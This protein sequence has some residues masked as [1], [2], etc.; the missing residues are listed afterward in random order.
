MSM[1][2]PSFFDHN[3]SSTAEM[4]LVASLVILSDSFSLAIS[5]N[6]IIIEAAIEEESMTHNFNPY[7]SLTSRSMGIDPA[8]GNW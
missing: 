2:E 7:Y 8:Y 6:F 1:Y 3:L 5:D 4:V